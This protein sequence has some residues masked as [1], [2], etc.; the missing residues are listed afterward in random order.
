M[1]A[2]VPLLGVQTSLHTSPPFLDDL[3]VMREAFARVVG[4]VHLFS[5]YVRY[6][7]FVLQDHHPQALQTW[8]HM[9]SRF[10]ENSGT[11]GVWSLST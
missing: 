9:S 1:M 4:G 3:L 7:K 2:G 8:R 10:V 6:R 11:S 5:W